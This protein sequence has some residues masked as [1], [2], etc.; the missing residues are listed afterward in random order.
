[1]VTVVAHPPRWIDS[2]DDNAEVE[3]PRPLQPRSSVMRMT[4]H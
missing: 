1:M 4:Q 3:S 2:E